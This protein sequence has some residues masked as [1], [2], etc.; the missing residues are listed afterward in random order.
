VLK[1]SKFIVTCGG[2]GC[3]PKAPGTWGSIG[4]L[5]FWAVVSLS[6]QSVTLYWSLLILSLFGGTLFIQDYEKRTQKKDPQEIVIDEWV[7]MGLALAFVP[8]SVWSLPLSFVLFRAF[9]IWK[10][11]GVRYFDDR[12]LKGWGTMLDDVVAGLYAGAILGVLHYYE[13]L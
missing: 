7:G 4:A 2:L 13:I 6:F 5:I 12:H 11:W 8:V 10:P 3:L 1:L 9:D